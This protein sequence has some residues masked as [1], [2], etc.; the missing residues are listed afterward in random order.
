M[1]TFIQP[2]ACLGIAALLL[3][4]I[5]PGSVSDAQAARPARDPSALQQHYSTAQ[6][7]QQAGKTD[8]ATREYRAFLA[9]AQQELAE[10]YSAA[11]DYAHAAS[12]FEQAL[13]LHADATELRIESAQNALS[14]GDPARAGTLAKSLLSDSAADV[15]TSAKAHQILG[16]ALLKQNQD[17]EAKAEFERA[18]ELEPS[19]ANRYDVAVACLDLDD[20]KCATQAFSGLEQTFGDTP[21]L[22]MQF[23]LAYGNSDFAP[24][25]IAEFRKAIAEDERLPGAHY[26]LAAALLSAGDDQKNVP[27]AEQELKTELGI[28]PHDALTYAAL[29]KLAVAD[30]RS[31]EAEKYL[32]TATSLD[33]RNPDAFLYLGQLYFDTGRPADAEAALRRAIA[34][35]KDPSRNR[36]QIQKAH[37]LLGRVLMQQHRSAEAR[38]EM[39]LARSFANKD[40]SHDKGEL[41]GLLNNPAA[42]GADPTPPT[43]TQDNNVNHAGEAGGA[44]NPS[45]NSAGPASSAAL[46]AFEQRLT[47]AIADSYNNLGV[48]AA[49]AGRYA[50]A[51]ADFNH[52]AEWNPTL[53]GLDLNRGRAAFM[54]SDFSDAIAPLSRYVKAHGSDPGV[55][56]ALAMSQ[57]MTGDYQGCL[58]TLHSVQNQ[59]ASIP[60]MAYVFAESLVKTGQTAEGRRRL[61]ILEAAHPEIADVHRALGEV[62][63]AARDR[64]KAA[65]ELHTALLLNSSD[66]QAHYDLG[67]LSVES[68]NAAA[69]IPELQ[70]A[71]RL[72]PND[73]T[74]HRE[75][76]LAYSL[77]SRKVDAR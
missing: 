19:F 71:V 7:L 14:A 52:A 5:S 45:S 44:N 4:S 13:A 23:G 24:R 32:K 1:K 60:Q 39:D 53:A 34:L 6:R 18:V 9:E 38:A 35:T 55:R 64:Q 10:D 20:D 11:G 41:A 22:H 27:E 67:K 65:G 72:S 56:G 76:A 74:F 8:E 47:P 73:A 62:Y 66:P 49:T 26:C 15:Q 57:F 43:G 28:S 59:L 36:F 29:G 50:E 77:S 21:A 46:R 25:A 42:T 70:T 69:A 58:E 68:G 2:G 3:G 16:R 33:P 31:A 54:A 48:I 12:L 61:E 63:A 37:F 40:L 17:R 30:H 75:L 51:L